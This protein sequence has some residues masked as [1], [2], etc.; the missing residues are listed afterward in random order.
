MFKPIIFFTLIFFCV[1]CG[2]HKTTLSED[3]PVKPADFFSAFPKLNLPFYV[4][5][6]NISKIITDTVTISHK[7]FQQFVPDSILENFTGNQINNLIINSVGKIEK[8]NE[9]YLLTKFTQGKKIILLCFLFDRKYHFIAALELLNNKSGD[10]YIH[11][12]N[13]NN[14]PTFL[15]SREKT[16]ANNQ[17][18]YTKNGYAFN[19]DAG[20][21][22][23]VINDSNEDVSKLNNIINPI[24]SF[25]KKNKYSGN[26]VQNKKNFIS[27]RDGKN[28]LVYNFF[29]HFEK[30]DEC[31]GELKGEMRLTSANKAIYQQ[32]GD[33]CVIDFE[34]ENKSITVKEEGN[35]GNHRGIK[36]YFDDTYK[37]RKN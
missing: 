15:V 32:S 18:F 16:T 8:G 10:N 2:E 30:D 23:I 12:V 36:C 37:K 25:P 33:A 26:Y 19:K 35:C 20:G 31:I 17:T 29:I 6:T 27:L 7:V 34:F 13:I 21:F 28:A 3:A 14:E 24:D 4:A 1:A 5:D 22:I 9:L 11:S